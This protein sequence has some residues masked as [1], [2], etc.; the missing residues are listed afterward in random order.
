MI[1]DGTST[2][3]AVG[4]LESFEAVALRHTNDLFRAAMS[5]LGN[6]QEAEDAVQEAYLR[7]WKAFDR[8]T[9]GTNCKAWM[10]KILLN[11]IRNHRRRWFRRLFVADDP[12]TLAENLVYQ[13]PVAESITDQQVLAAFQKLPP[14]F[15]EVIML[16]DVYEFTYK[17]VQQTLGIPL[18]TVMSR[19]SRGRGLLREYLVDLAPLSVSERGAAAT[20]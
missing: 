5:M 7:A 17:E 13:A 19:L 3:Q 2:D 12:N 14:R 20:V 6:R 16:A 18:G 9:P 15:A 4:R 10:F 11:V 1:S 8:F